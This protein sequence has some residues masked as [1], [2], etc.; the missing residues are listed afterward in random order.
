[1]LIGAW[2]QSSFLFPGPQY[3]YSIPCSLSGLC[4]IREYSLVPRALPAFSTLHEKSGRT[5]YQKSHDQF[6]L[7]EGWLKGENEHGREAKVSEVLDA[8]IHDL[9]EVRLQNYQTIVVRLF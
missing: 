4:Y 1:M 9:L 3:I 5:W 8:A 7:Y 6:Y 2:M